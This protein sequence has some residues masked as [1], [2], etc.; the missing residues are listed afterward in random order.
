MKHD[1]NKTSVAPYIVAERA[2]WDAMERDEYFNHYLPPKMA[3]IVEELCPKLVAR[4]EMLY[5]NNPF[6]RKQL[7]DK[8]RDIRYTLEVFMWHWAFPLLE[9]KKK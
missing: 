2:L 8:R 4:A 3:A 5:Q 9:S 1:I 6:F 7:N